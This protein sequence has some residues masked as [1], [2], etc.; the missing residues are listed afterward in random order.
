MATMARQ[1]AAGTMAA[2]RIHASQARPFAGARVMRRRLRLVV[3]YGSGVLP[4]LVAE[5]HFLGALL[6]LE[7]VLFERGTLACRE[8]SHQ[9]LFRGVA[10]DAR[11]VVHKR[12]LSHHACACPASAY[13]F[14]RHSRNRALARWT[15][16][17]R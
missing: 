11:F 17:R 3:E 15:S 4:E 12:L 13:R 2:G 1:A 6:T 14:S 5:T 9:V 10:F 8:L 16:T 7:E